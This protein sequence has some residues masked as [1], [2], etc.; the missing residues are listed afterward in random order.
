MKKYLSLLLSICLF[1]SI[2]KAQFELQQIQV[3]AG[4]FGQPVGSAFKFSTRAN[5]GYF[6]ADR[7]SV[8]IMPHFART[9][10]VNRNG[11]NQRINN[12][13]FSVYG[14]YYFRLRFNKNLDI[15][16][17]PEASLGLG[18]RGYKENYGLSAYA[19]FGPGG[20]YFF[21]EYWAV[22]VI[23]PVVLQRKLSDD[24]IDDDLTLTPVLGVQY[25]F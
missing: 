3:G 13:A 17:F 8:G 21:A 24:F 19:S 12:F 25:Y 16:V 4:L 18:T 20:T 22:E 1:C 11:D 23:L 6:V 7:L 14:R 2:G 9:I 10:Q 15:A 5:I